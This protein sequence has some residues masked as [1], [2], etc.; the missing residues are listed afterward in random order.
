M[1]QRYVLQARIKGRADSAWF[2]FGDPTLPHDAV[3]SVDML[4]A[5]DPQFEYRAVPLLPLVAS[6][7]TSVDWLLPLLLSAAEVRVLKGALLVEIAA[8]EFRHREDVQGDAFL[9]SLK[10]ARRVFTVLCDK[11]NKQLLDL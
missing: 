8:L 11:A 4:N 10:A 2:P 6:N 5:G 9:P 7:A 1:D 3:A